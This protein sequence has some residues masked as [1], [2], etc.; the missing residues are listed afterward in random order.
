ME[1]FGSST[2]WD[3]DWKGFVEP[4][5]ARRALGSILEHANAGKFLELLARQVWPQAKLNTDPGESGYSKHR[6]P[7]LVETGQFGPSG[8]PIMETKTVWDW[9]SIMKERPN[10]KEIFGTPV[11]QPLPRSDA[12]RAEVNEASMKRRKYLL[13]RRNF[14][15][16]TGNMNMVKQIDAQLANLQY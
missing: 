1:I 12:D 11:G 6:V 16:R 15:I 14:W 10:T 2:P 9:D 4:G 3:E 5:P 7:K 13:E 8:T